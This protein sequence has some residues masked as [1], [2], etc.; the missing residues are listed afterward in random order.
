MLG[1]TD[2]PHFNS[3]LAMIAYHLVDTDAIRALEPSGFNV[4]GDL[5]HDVLDKLSPTDTFSC[6]EIPSRSSDQ[7]VLERMLPGAAR[8]TVAG[9][10][11]S[12]LVSRFTAESVN[13]LLRP[14]DVQ[15][16]PVNIGLGFYHHPF[17]RF[18]WPGEE[19]GWAKIKIDPAILSLDCDLTA[20]LNR[21]EYLPPDDIGWVRTRGI[22]GHEYGHAAN[23]ALVLVDQEKETRG[24]NLD[25]STLAFYRDA[26]ESQHNLAVAQEIAPNKEL[27]DLLSSQP[28]GLDLMELGETAIERVSSGFEVTALYHALIDYGVDTDELRE[29]TGD[30]LY[31]SQPYFDEFAHVIRLAAQKGIAMRGLSQALYSIGEG[32]DS[33]PETR[34]I[35]A[36][37]LK[38][39]YFSPDRM[40]YFFPLTKAE[41]AAY[42]RYWRETLGR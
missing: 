37:D 42:N 38:G 29:I 2:T 26:L 35:I 10:R 23:D 24:K 7:A 39:K 9:F 15:A 6:R 3:P 8:R 22:F 4:D 33:I 11:R 14:Q 20:F 13:R 5:T 17:S 31:V 41:L 18:P 12:G 28:D 34:S 32:F 27:I 36:R 25:S 19:K 30:D 40:G 1:E 21:A 16:Q